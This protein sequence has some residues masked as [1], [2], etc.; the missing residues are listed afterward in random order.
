MTTPQ[1]GKSQA[2]GLELPDRMYPPNAKSINRRLA[3][4]G[5]E[6]VQDATEAQI[7]IATWKIHDALGGHGL[8]TAVVAIVAL[9]VAL[10]ANNAAP[11]WVAFGLIIVVGLLT[12]F[13][14]IDKR[15]WEAANAVLHHRLDNSRD[16][17]QSG[18]HD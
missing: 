10:N 9:S 5:E 15:N 3:A 18:H 7:A 12:I 6:P 14:L 16:G 17:G 4:I 8:L 2:K 1:R 11:A 13:V